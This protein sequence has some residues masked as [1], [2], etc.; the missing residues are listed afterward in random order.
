[1]QIKHMTEYIK[2]L[3]NEETPTFICI[4]ENRLTKFCIGQVWITMKYSVKY[5]II[6]RM[7]KNQE[8]S[9]LKNWKEFSEGKNNSW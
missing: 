5:L 4:T 8:T 3:M 9:P 2:M 1:M 7:L 6:K